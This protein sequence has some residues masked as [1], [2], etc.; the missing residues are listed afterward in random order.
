MIQTPTKIKTYSEGIDTEHYFSMDKEDM[1]EI[2]KI[3]RSSVYSNKPLCVI[4]EYSSN[5]MDSHI[6]VGKEN[7][8][9]E[10]TMPNAFNLDLKIKDFGLGLSEEDVYSIFTKYGKSTKRQK[11][12]LTGSMGIGSKSAFALT[13]SFTVIST[14][15]NLKT[16]YLCYLDESGLG[17]C[18]K[19]H[20]EILSPSLP[21]R[22]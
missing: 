7:L 16:T 4:K 1:N 2:F 18:S 5:A 12:L 14:F 22:H 3:L 19:L 15:N 21:P 11:K 17:K 20:S 10:I 8:P 13:D 6:D 9:I